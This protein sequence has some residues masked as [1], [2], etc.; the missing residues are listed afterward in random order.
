MRLCRL[1]DLPDTMEG[2]VFHD[3]LPGEQI[4]T[5]G[6]A[7]AKPGERSHTNDGPG[8][9]DRHVHEDCEAFLDHPGPGGEFEIDRASYPIKTSADLI[10]VEPGEGHHLVVDRQDPLVTLWCH[11]GS[12]KRDT[13]LNRVL[14]ERCEKAG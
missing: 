14:E 8:G 7:F 4:Y 3:L 1:K 5:G 11:A 10:V 12:I 2:H 13:R 9:M 6:L